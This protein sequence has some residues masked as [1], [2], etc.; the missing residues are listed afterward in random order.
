MFVIMSTG[1]GCAC[2]AVLLG[3]WCGG[4]AHLWKISCDLVIASNSKLIGGVGKCVIA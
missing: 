2:V 4:S 3:V 1:G